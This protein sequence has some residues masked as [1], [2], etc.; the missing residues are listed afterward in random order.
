M[1][2][3]PKI[4]DAVWVAIIS[5]A[6]TLPFL[7]KPFHID[8]TLMLLLAENVV[9]DPLDPYAGTV[10]EGGMVVVKSGSTSDADR[11]KFENSMREDSGPE[12]KLVRQLF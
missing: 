8:D 2:W 11:G 6:A 12:I 1:N 3:S 10:P 4:R 7:D 5:A 9:Q